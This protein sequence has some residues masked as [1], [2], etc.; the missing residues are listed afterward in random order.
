MHGNSKRARRDRGG[1][2]GLF[3]K[4]KPSASAVWV[5]LLLAATCS[6]SQAQSSEDPGILRVH[7]SPALQANEPLRIA[8]GEYAIFKEYDGIGPVDAEI[9]HFQEDWRLS[10]TP[11]GNY[12]VEGTRSFESPEHFPRQ[13]HFL[14]R[15]SPQLQ[16]MEVQEDTSLTWFWRSAPLACVFLPQQ[17]R[18]AAWGKDPRQEADL[19]LSMERPYAFS[20]PLSAF[21]LGA[22]TRQCDYHSGQTMEVEFVDIE[23]PSS[24]LPLMPIITNGTLRFL[25]QENVTV[26][27]T[28]WLANKFEL[29]AFL[30]P[31]PRKSILWVSQGGLLLELDAERE[32]GPKGRLELTR[33]ERATAGSLF[34]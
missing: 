22:L 23:Q 9:F 13:I 18:C 17:L 10:R 4:R 2:R 5:A 27:G 32:M 1:S 20:W 16:L 25:G 29:R 6:L 19:S 28:N 15:L 34:P 26:A 11:D 24:D 21:S 7:N 30:S 31:L 12:E 3:Q 8:E 14:L 33:L